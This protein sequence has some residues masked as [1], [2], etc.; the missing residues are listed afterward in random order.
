MTSSWKSD[1]G[2]V[3]VNSGANRS[4]R[5]RQ[6]FSGLCRRHVQQDHDDGRLGV[7][8]SLM[9][10]DNGLV[11]GACRRGH[12][13]GHGTVPQFLVA[14]RDVDHEVPVSLTEPDHGR[15]GDHVEDGFLCRSG[16]QTGRPGEHL[17]AGVDLDGQIGLVTDEGVMVATH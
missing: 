2:V 14:R 12:D 9:K 3:L 6:S 8:V 1:V 16:L 13:D 11:P 7:T 15:R 4:A 17:W 5:C 10:G